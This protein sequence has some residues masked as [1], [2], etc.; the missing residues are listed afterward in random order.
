MAEAEEQYGVPAWLLWS[1]G[2]VESGFNPY[3][4]NTN[5]NGTRDVCLM[6]INTS[7]LPILARYGIREEHLWDT[8][9][10]VKVGAWVMAQNIQAHGWNWD[11]IGAYN[12]RSPE[13]R[14]RYAWKIYRA[15][16]DAAG[17]PGAGGPQP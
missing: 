3:A 13:K 16:A 2:K 17:E 11:A 15:V 5:K 6:Q 14:N 8:C 12:A 10:C 4:V 7:W 1:V 9:T